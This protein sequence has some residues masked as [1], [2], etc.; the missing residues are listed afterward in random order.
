MFSRTAARAIRGTTLLRNYQ[1][2]GLV[3]RYSVVKDERSTSSLPLAGYRVL[4]MTRVLAGP[5]CTQILGDL[6]YKR[7]ITFMTQRLL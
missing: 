2:V 6:G 1:Q 3:R 4:D 7:Y 5:Y